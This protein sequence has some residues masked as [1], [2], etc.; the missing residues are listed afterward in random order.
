VER[1]IDT[2]ALT[3]DDAAVYACCHPGMIDDLKARIVP[4]GFTVQLDR[5]QKQGWR[6]VPS[7]RGGRLGWGPK[8]G[9]QIKVD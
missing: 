7:H 9:N 6:K 3:P 8:P 5:L 2:F 1:H 4:R